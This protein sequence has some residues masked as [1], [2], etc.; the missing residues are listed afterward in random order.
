M[1]IQ[2]RGFIPPLSDIFTSALYSSRRLAVS[3][4]S[5]IITGIYIFKNIYQVTG[6]CFH[7][8]AVENKFFKQKEIFFTYTLTRGP[9]ATTL[10]W[11]NFLEINITKLIKRRKNSLSTLWELNNSSFEQTW[12]TFTQGCTVA[13]LVEIGP[14]VLEKKIFNFCWR[15]TTDNRQILIRKAH[16]SLSSGELKNAIMMNICE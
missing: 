8:R 2:L 16:L 13:G 6:S 9:W 5:V 3:L 11:E 14:V 12:I 1:I 4:R 7:S 15:T 10:T